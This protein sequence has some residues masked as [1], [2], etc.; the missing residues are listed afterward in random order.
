MP[1]PNKVESASSNYVLIQQIGAINDV[2]LTYQEYLNEW[3]GAIPD[4]ALVILTM[5]S[6][7]APPATNEK[8]YRWRH[9]F[10][11]STV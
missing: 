11:L 1:C 6:I 10:S 3:T 9:N 4:P 2:T 5:Y 7:G 8:K